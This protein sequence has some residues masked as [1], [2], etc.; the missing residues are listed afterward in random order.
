MPGTSAFVA[1]VEHLPTR[2]LIGF[3][4]LVKLPIFYSIAR[5]RCSIKLPVINLAH[6]LA[7]TGA[8]LPLLPRYVSITVP[9]WGNHHQ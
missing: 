3:L 1:N 8:P 7:H 2:T 5:P 4:W 9:H 6:V